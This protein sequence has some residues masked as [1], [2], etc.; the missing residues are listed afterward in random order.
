MF[1][2]SLHIFKDS[3]EEAMWMVAY[4]QDEAT[5]KVI[6]VLRKGR[7]A[8]MRQTTIANLELQAAVH[9]V[10]LRRQILRT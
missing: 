8:P 10:R 7:V 9:G 2:L 6:N 4:L 3:S 1:K 5:F